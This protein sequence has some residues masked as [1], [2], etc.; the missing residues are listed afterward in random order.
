MVKHNNV[1]ANA[2]FRKHW[3][4][5]VRTWFDQPARK[6][7]R[8]QTRLAK[9]KAVFPRPLKRL[10]PIVKGKDIRYNAH[11]R[12]GRGFTPA[13]LKEAGLTPFV[14]RSIGIAVDRRRKNKSMEGLQRNVA[15]L[16]TYMSKLVLFP[17]NPEKPKARDASAEECQNVVQHTLSKIMPVQKAQPSV[18][19]VKITPEMKSFG[20]WTKLQEERKRAKEVGKD[21]EDE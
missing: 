9:A 7:R 6:Y 12:L 10:R 17:R 8:R 18:D 14:A 13:E 20:A 15:R 4:R 3:Q 11:E 19:F 1:V 21:K 16:K 5:R 2:H